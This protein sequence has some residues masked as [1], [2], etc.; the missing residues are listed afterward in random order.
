M[1]AVFWASVALLVFGMYCLWTLPD[2]WMKYV[3]I[4]FISIGLVGFG[5]SAMW[6][7]AEKDRGR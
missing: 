6:W 3:S 5:G 4:V 7:A 1:K 2:L